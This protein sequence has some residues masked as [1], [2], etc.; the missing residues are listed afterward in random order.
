MNK[1]WPEVLLVLLLAGVITSGAVVAIKTVT[2]ANLNEA[3]I[4][5]EEK[6]KRT[7]ERSKFWQ[8]LTPWA[9]KDPP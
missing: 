6:T 8:N 1:E 9:K 3:R 4:I 7:V 5:Q 2:A